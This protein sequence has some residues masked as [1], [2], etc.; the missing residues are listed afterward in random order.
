MLAVE[1]KAVG[2]CEVAPPPSESPLTWRQIV[3][4]VEPFLRAV[5]DSL[6]EQVAEFEPEIA[7][8]ARQALTSQ[9]KQLRPALMALSAEATGG[10]DE[11]LVKAATIIEMVHLATLV[12]DDVMDEAEIRRRRPTLAAQCGNSISVL[13]GDCLFAQAVRLA[14]SFPTPVV[15]HAVAAATRI[16]CEGEILQNQHRWQFRLSR[17]E[18]LRVLRMKTGE[19]FALSCD[20]GAGLS[21]AGAAERA[22][23][24]A[25]GLALGTAYQVYDDCLDLFGAEAT[26]GK[27][28]GTDLARGKVTLPIIVALE[29]ATP[30]DRHRLAALLRRWQRRQLPRLLATL[31]RYDALADSCEVAHQLCR[32]ARQALAGLEANAGREALEVVTEFLAQQAGALGVK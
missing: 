32:A 16:V 24:R 4:P 23:L 9:G 15:C 30:A 27:S 7:A 31:G 19:L 10:L 22:A 8:Y 25:Y 18:Y 1:S 14:A 12:H 11:G 5:A 3:A 6:A 20:L 21:G 17:R 29:R 2:A 28:L 26:V 13:V